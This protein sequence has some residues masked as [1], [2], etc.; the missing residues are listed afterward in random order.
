MSQGWEEI[1]GKSELA[2]ELQVSC[3]FVPWNLA[4]C[5]RIGHNCTKSEG[6]AKRQ[7]TPRCIDC[8][9]YLVLQA[10]PI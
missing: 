3:S 1:V 8:L 6:W 2:C 10:V 5:L 7:A 9:L 4:L